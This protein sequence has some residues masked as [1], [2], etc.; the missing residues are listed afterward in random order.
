ML[1]FVGAK[2]PLVDTYKIPALVSL[3]VIASILTPAVGA[4][5]WAR[6]REPGPADAPAA[7]R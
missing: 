7:L 5:V 1:V 6:R 2:T 4:S 3:A